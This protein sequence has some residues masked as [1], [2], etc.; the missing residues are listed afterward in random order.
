MTVRALIV[1]DEP[2]SRRILRDFAVDVDWLDIIGE[3]TDGRMAVQMIDRLQPDLVFL[4]VQLPKLTGLQ[5]LERV[6]CEPAI[7]FTTAYHRYAIAAFELEALDYLLKPI[8][9]ARFHQAMERG[10]QRLTA[11]KEA[12]DKLP[13][14]RERAALALQHHE[15]FEPLQRMFVRDA[16]GKIIHLRL[17]DVSRF[18]AADDYVAVHA[19]KTSYLVHLTLN[20]FEQRLDRK[21]F[22]RVHRSV[23]VNLDHVVSCQPM[24]RRLL[25]KLRDGS[26]VSTSRAG[27]QSLQDLII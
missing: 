8:G 23:I 21:Q 13:S 25:L 18:V 4:D 20:D 14:V 27:S 1:D 17:D 11:K 22:R 15:T 9:R 24:E 16:R 12:A 7:V 6:S 10:R 5:V 26:E 3:A 19:N 2:L